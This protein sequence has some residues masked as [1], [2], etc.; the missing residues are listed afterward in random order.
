MSYIKGLISKDQVKGFLDYLAC[1]GMHH[2]EGKGIYELAQVLVNG[3]YLSVT[4]DGRNKVG[5]PEGLKDTAT[6]YLAQGI[7]SINPVT[8][9]TLNDACLYDKG[10]A[11]IV[12]S[13]VQKVLA[14]HGIKLVIP[15]Y[16]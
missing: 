16:E 5:L 2:R 1:K 15:Q 3:K 12:T 9:I 4:I 6:E 7:Q 13:E 14:S 11:L 10:G 8:E